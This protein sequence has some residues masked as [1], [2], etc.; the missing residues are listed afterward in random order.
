[1]PVLV[2]AGASPF[3]QQGELTGSRTEFIHWLQDVFDQRGIVR[4]YMR[5]ENEIRTGVNV[6]QMV[7]RALQFA[8]SDPRGPVYL[9]GAREVMEQE[10]VRAEVDRTCWP[11]LAKAPAAESFLDALVAALALAQRPLVVTSYV[12]R[13]T[14]AVAELVGF[15]ELAGAGVLESV[16]NY[17]NFPA[18]H[19]LYQ[20]VQ[21]NEPRQ[22][23]ALAAAD[24]VIVIDS[25]VPWIPTVNKPQDGIPVFHIDVDPLKEDIPLWQLPAKHAV[26]ANAATVLRQLNAK[27]TGSRTG[28]FWRSRHAAWARDLAAREAGNSGAIT[29][30][31]AEYL[32][33]RLRRQL[34]ADTIVL[35][36]AVTSYKAVAEGLGARREGSVF[37]S[38][39]GSLGWNGGA[40]IGFKLAEPKKTVV[41]I[42]GDGSFMFSIPATVHWMARRYNTPFLQIVLNNGGWRAPRLSATTVHPGGYASRGADIGTAFE[43]PP[44]Y[45]G[46]AAAAGGALA[47]K[48]EDRAEVDEAIARGLRAVQ[49]EGRSAVLDVLMADRATSS[50]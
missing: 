46:I 6:K 33:S 42:T 16:P 32:T 14:E 50:V 49:T 40:A 47:L 13:R 38:G 4:Q 2:F 25:D 9:M 48:V 7:Y 3:T 12:G 37:T 36:E 19:A 5:Y 28:A 15:A 27:L 21:G 44:D 10:T 23:E 24:L 17:M 26:K 34:G 8:E 41:A 45:G 22:S 18:G 35:N 1:V 43:M 30:I 31:T 39:G 20:G 29:A 11:L